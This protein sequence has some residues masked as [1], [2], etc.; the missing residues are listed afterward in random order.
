MRDH[1]LHL[2][3]LCCLFTISSPAQ[4]FLEAQTNY[5][6]KQIKVNT[7][8]EIIIIGDTP[9]PRAQKYLDQTRE[10]R[11]AYVE[12]NANHFADAY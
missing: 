7:D 8:Q 9:S 5:Q 6:E 2:T 3:I 4:G 1:I 11:A 12:A 10:A